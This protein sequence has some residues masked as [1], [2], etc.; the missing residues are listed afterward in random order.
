MPARTRVR[1]MMNI[2][3]KN[4]IYTHRHFTKHLVGAFRKS[5]RESDLNNESSSLLIRR[6]KNDTGSQPA[7]SFTKLGIPKLTTRDRSISHRADRNTNERD[8]R[9][10][11]SKRN[12]QR[13][14]RGARAKS[15]VA[16]MLATGNTGLALVC[17]HGIL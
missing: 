4:N 13:V 9:A 6:L 8:Q 2:R 15:S 10:L 14:N 7:R 16:Q 1:L 17:E 12:S 3:S 5:P 11:D